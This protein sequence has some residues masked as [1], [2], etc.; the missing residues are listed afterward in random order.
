MRRSAPAADFGCPH[1]AARLVLAAFL[2]CA[3][4]AWAGVDDCI[5]EYAGAHDFNGSI[6]V[7]KGDAVLSSGSFGPAN[8]QHRVRNT[9]DL[10]EF[11]AGIGKRAVE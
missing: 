5:S 1:N 2:V 3:A 11:V 9:T 4:Q 7:R 10:D 8:F 6:L